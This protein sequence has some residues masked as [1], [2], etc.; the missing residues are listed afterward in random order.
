MTNGIPLP[1]PWSVNVAEDEDDVGRILDDARRARR[2]GAELVLVNMHWGPEEVSEPD[3]DQLR[4]ARALTRSPEVTAVV[5]QG[6]HVVQPIERMNGKYVVFSEGNLISNQ[7]AFCCAEAT[8]DGLIALLEIVVDGD[9]ARVD[10]IRYVPVYVRHP[11]YAVLPVGTAME[12]GE[13]DAATA[14]SS[15]ERTVSVAGR[16]PGIRPEPGRL[17]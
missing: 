4:Q 5:G 14:S 12:Q 16:G 8:Q 10:G 15:Y 7:D 3:A 11:D 2:M 17:R 13:L 6:P 9:G 1:E